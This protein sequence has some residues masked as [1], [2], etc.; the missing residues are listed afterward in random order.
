MKMLLG[1]KK[2]RCQTS[3][4]KFKKIHEV[5]EGLGNPRWQPGFPKPWRSRRFQR[6]ERPKTYFEINVKPIVKMMASCGTR[7]IWA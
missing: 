3:F 6:S 5:F 1:R 7:T 4:E 2:P